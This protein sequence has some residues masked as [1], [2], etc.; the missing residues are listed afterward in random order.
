ME[1]VVEIVRLEESQEGTFGALRLNKEL[2]C[3]TLEPQDR[4]NAA[5]VSSIPRATVPLPA[6]AFAALWRDLRGRG[7][8]WA[9]RGAPAPRQH[10]RRHPRLHSAGRCLG[11]GGGRAR[12]HGQ[13]RGVQGLHGQA[14][15]ARRLSPDDLRT[16]L[17]RRRPAPPHGMDD[18]DDPDLPGGGGG[19]GPKGGVRP[20]GRRRST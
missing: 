2:I 14:C 6:H 15:G 4:L 18:E 11:A 5:D 17:I 1:P 12:G 16:L 7:R 3:A 13:P 9:Q 19:D 8:A 10:P 20:A